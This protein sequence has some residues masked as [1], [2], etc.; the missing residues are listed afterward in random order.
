MSQQTTDI[1]IEYKEQEFFVPE[2]F[3]KEEYMQ[4]LS[5]RF[6]ELASSKLEQNDDGSFTAKALV[7]TKG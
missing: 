3:T 2:G 7:G 5:I 6:P 1:K 4:S